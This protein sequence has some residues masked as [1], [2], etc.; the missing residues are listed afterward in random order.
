[1]YSGGPTSGPPLE[2]L[3]H[4]C[5]SPEVES[6][7]VCIYLYTHVICIHIPTYVY[8]ICVYICTHL[9]IVRSS[10]WLL[11]VVEDPP[12][13]HPPPLEWRIHQCTSPDVESPPVH[14]YTY[15]YIYMYSGGPTSGPP[16]EW[17]TH[18]RTSLKWR[19]HQ[20]NCTCVNNA[21]IYT[22]MCIY[23]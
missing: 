20:C 14:V 22:Y 7:P 23:L 10:S 8:N 16:L 4:Q 18:Q 6:P 11:P 2:W 19:N 17:L 12:V 5:T 13:G 1:M 3:I 21:C 9:W 15:I